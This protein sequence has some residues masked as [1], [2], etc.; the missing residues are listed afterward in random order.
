MR[1]GLLLELDHLAFKAVENFHELVS[2]QFVLLD[3]FKRRREFLEL[4]RLDI[5]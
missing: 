3:E 4:Y 2:D 1:F 5:S